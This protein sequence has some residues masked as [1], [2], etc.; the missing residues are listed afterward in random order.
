M[1]TRVLNEFEY[2]RPRSLAEAISLL[3][4]YGNKAKVLAGGTDLLIDMK[5]LR[6]RPEYLGDITGINELK[7]ITS[8]EKE[9]RIGAITLLSEI[10]NSRLI[11][12]RY[13]ALFE[14]TSEMATTQIRNLATIGGNL[15]NASP[16][17]DTAPPLI[18]LEAKAEIASQS[19]I[20]TVPLEEFFTGPGETVLTAGD[21]LTAILIPAPAQHMGTS[22]IK[23]SR[24][25][26]DLAILNVAV[27]L[28]TDNN[29][30]REVRI[31]L[32]AV[33]PTPIRA[34]KAEDILTNRELTQDTIE[35]A[36]ST[37]TEEIKPISD[38][39]STSD[40]RR[41][42]AAVITKRALLRAYERS[43]KS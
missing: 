30:C 11:Q 5:L 4:K 7:G 42:V 3:G 18:V 31:A 38:V 13:A 35:K 10:G 20:R 23:I 28:I 1:G 32:G 26:S 14:A 24:T 40:Y 8:N 29:T 15:C 27:A 16:A 19:G 25:A 43:K 21:I 34:K 37:V 39:R 41:D 6:K 2:L 36:A 33:A 22:F 9:L 12:D 17:A